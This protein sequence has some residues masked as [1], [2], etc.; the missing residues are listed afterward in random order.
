MLDRDKLEEWF[1]GGDVVTVSPTAIP[2]AAIN[3]PLRELLTEVGLPESLL[4][5]VVLGPT[6]DSIETVEQSYGSIGEDAPDGTGHLL[7]L[8]LAGTRSLCVNGQTGE[9]LEVDEEFGSRP[10]NSNL[11][12]FLRVL[13]FVS[14]E[15]EA[16]IKES[17]VEGGDSQVLKFA[18]NLKRRTLEKL[19]K[20]DPD[21]A[22]AAESAWSQLVGNI[23]EVL[24]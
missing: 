18:E 17:W 14:V 12:A 24:T 10:F 4:G 20:I 16:Y 8:G 23:T 3:E 5:V 19:G 6:G 7:Y 15:V 22:S 9:V 11:E 1:P 13:G 21:K 2:D